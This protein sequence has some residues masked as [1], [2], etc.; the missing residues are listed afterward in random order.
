MPFADCGDLDN[1]LRPN[2]DARLQIDTLS[3][4]CSHQY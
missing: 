3:V 4:C 1:S 2:A